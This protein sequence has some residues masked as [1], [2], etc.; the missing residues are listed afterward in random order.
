MNKDVGDFESLNFLKAKDI[1]SSDLFLLVYIYIYTRI[2]YMFYSFIFFSW[3][4][5]F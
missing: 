3:P 4:Q 5:N 2:V 1:L